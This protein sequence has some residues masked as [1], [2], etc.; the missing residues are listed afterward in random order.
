MTDMSL[1]GFIG[2]LAGAHER[3][4]DATHR[5]LEKAA[6]IIESEAKAE[7]GTYQG[8]AGPFAAWQ[9]LADATKADRVAQGFKENDPLLRTGDMRDSIGHVVSGHEAAVGS[10]SDIAVFQEMGTSKIPPRSFLGGAAFRKAED[11]AK[12]LGH[13]AVMGLVG[14]GATIKI[15]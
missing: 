9:E 6:R 2:F 11:V 8:Q 3:I 14:R 12:V 15:K 5:G 13:S 10:D 1:A 4:E 7:I